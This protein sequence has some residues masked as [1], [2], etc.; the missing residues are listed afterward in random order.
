MD[1]KSTTFIHSMLNLSLIKKAKRKY[2]EEGISS[3]SVHGYRF[4]KQRFFELLVWSI[5]PKDRFL[6]T[7]SRSR[8]LTHIYFFLTGTY[9]HE[10]RALLQGLAT[11]HDT[12]SSVESRKFRMIRN[13]H[14]IE[15]GLSIPDKKQKNTF[16]E[17]YINE[18]VT[19][20]SFLW[21]TNVDNKQ[22]RWAIDVL[23][24]YFDTVDQTEIIRESEEEF[25]SFLNE[26]SYTPENRTPFLRS[27]IND[28][29]VDYEDLRTLAINRTSTRRF[30]Q[31]NVP[32][33]LVDKS[34]E[35]ALQSPSA[36]N[37]QAYEF[38]IYDSPEM[39]D[40]IT[41][42]SIGASG[43]KDNIP[44]L[45]VIVGKQR[46][47]FDERDKHVIYIDASHAAMS[48]QLSLETQGL[49]SCCIN[50]P[51]IPR[52]QRKIREVM[53]LTDD[54]QVVMLMAIGYPDPNKKVPYSEKKNL[55]SIRSYNKS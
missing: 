41:D 44:M 28:S 22:L 17:K 39:I 27:E 40:K 11:Y 25:N 23:A 30:Q 19:D 32:R 8:I 31:K 51:A 6:R 49:A 10:Q 21:N 47:Y 46:A 13:I 42:L 4:A 26:I 1:G 48:F 12:E 18:V 37:R 7:I 54:E 45:A 3:L 36:C 55:E 5:I 24:D 20:V 43:Y 38:R 33:E 29:P 16:A 53:D 52:N 14:R 34:L 35:V 50:W 2:Q 9:Y 15:K